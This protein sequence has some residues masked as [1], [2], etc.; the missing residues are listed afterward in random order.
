MLRL[1]KISD[2]EKIIFA[3]YLI[4]GILLA[5]TIP[6]EA[7]TTYFYY[8]STVSI[9]LL[10]IYISEKSVNNK[11]SIL[12]FILGFIIFGSI[13][14]FRK[15]TG[16]DDRAYYDIYRIAKV[17]S[18]SR[19]INNNPITSGMERGYL[20]ISYFFSK[21]LK[22]D[23]NVF[24]IVITYFSFSI[25]AI[26]IWKYKNVCSITLSTLVLWTHYYFM[27]MGA[28]LLRIFAAIPFAF[29]SLYYLTNRNN[30][31]FFVCL[32]LG[33]I[34][35]STILSM[36]IVY[37]FFRNDFSKK[38]WFMYLIIITIA[39]P[40]LLRIASQLFG[41]LL[42]SRFS[43]YIVNGNMNISLSDIDMLPIGLIGTYLYPKIDEKYK[44]LYLGGIICCYFSV[45]FSVYTYLLSISRLTYYSN[46]GAIIVIS[47]A[48]KIEH[49]NKIDLYIIY[50]LI[51]YLFLFLR[52]TMLNDYN[53][54]NIFPYINIF[55]KI[56]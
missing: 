31:L 17:T 55:N 39:F 35:H 23:Y 32:L 28:G 19:Y 44:K 14:A 8:F 40:I 7:V 18:F 13:M 16:T 42:S 51:F 24:Q 49:K 27:I 6:V 26:A 12:L 56:Y 45:I 5:F 22:L 36:L 21:I 9:S 38:N 50:V 20:A 47:G 41:T 34:F 11:L 33:S 54:S 46:L 3:E 29:L 30:K 2:Q 1:Y 25:W 10:L 53:Y 15:Q 4:L 37:P 48:S 52:S 43:V